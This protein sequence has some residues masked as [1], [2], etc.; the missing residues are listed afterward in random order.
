MSWPARRGATATGRGH[1]YRLPWTLKAGA[2]PEADAKTA[3]NIN[4]SPAAEESGDNGG[5]RSA[6]ERV[7]DA[8]ESRRHGHRLATKT[9]LVQ[10]WAEERA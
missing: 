9:Q 2:A 6:E 7:H 4:D 10:G 1:S 3:D 8:G 5:G